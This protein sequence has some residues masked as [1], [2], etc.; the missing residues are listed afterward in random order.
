MLRYVQPGLGIC[1]NLVFPSDPAGHSFTDW[2]PEGDP[3][4]TATTVAA[5]PCAEPARDATTALHALFATLPVDEHD[6]G[7]LCPDADVAAIPAW[8]LQRIDDNANCVAV[9]TSRSRRK[10]ALQQA[11]MERTGHRQLYEIVAGR[12]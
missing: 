12:G 11:A 3:S 2:W 5:W 6:V 1:R 4:R 10:L 7:W 9:A 8:T